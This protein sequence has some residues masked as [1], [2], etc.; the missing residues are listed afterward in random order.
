MTAR[1]G[2]QVQSLAWGWP[3]RGGGLPLGP[4][5][6]PTQGRGPRERSLPA[7]PHLS[8]PDAPRSS[9]KGK[10]LSGND[11]AGRGS[12]AQPAPSGNGVTICL[13]PRVGTVTQAQRPPVRSV[14]SLS[15]VLSVCQ[16][17]T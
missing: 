2:L 5:G 15:Q 4:G 13:P 14:R 6:A 8:G 7:L 3:R 10:N 1:S 16:V 11:R 12:G 17:L 9:E